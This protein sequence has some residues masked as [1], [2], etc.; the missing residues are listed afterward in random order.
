[1]H[2]NIYMCAHRHIYKE[3]LFS[4]KYKISVHATLW[5]NLDFKLKF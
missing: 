4:Y 2:I 5:L 3:L 1:M